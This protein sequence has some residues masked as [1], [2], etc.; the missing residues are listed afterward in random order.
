MNPDG[1]S[2]GF[3][4]QNFSVTGY[5]G[6]PEYAHWGILGDVTLLTVDELGRFGT[7]EG[8]RFYWYDAPGYEPGWYDSSEVPLSDGWGSDIGPL[9]RGLLVFGKNLTLLNAGFVNDGEI[10]FELPKCGACVLANPRS[11]RLHPTDVTVSG[12]TGTTS[13]AV[14]LSVLDSV[15]RPVWICRWIDNPT[16]YPDGRGWYYNDVSTGQMTICKP[17]DKSLCCE[18]GDGWWVQGPQNSQTTYKFTIRKRQA[19]VNE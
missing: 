2:T 16:Y 12:Y 9:G 5:E 14:T 18:P 1:S 13:G 7:D 6:K 19:K 15:G 17:G 8:S 4:P 11:T 10:T 3:K